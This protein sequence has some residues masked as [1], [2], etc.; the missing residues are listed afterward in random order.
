MWT[1]RISCIL[2]DNISKFCFGDYYSEGID[3]L[4]SSFNDHQKLKFKKI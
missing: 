4:A 2:F 1:H 3:D